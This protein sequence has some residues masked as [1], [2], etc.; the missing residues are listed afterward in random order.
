MIHYLEDAGLVP[1][2]WNLRRVLGR[3]RDYLRGLEVSGEVKVNPQTGMPELGG[4]ITLGEP[5]GEQRNQGYVSA[6]YLLDLAEKALATV[7]LKV[8]IALDRLILGKSLHFP[9]LSSL[10]RNQ[11]TNGIFLLGLQHT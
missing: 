2:E 7:K 4:K 1:K 9:I 5:S 10:V 8:W 3:V 11:R 6:D